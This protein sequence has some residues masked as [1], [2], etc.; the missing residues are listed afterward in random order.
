M[1]RGEHPKPRVECEGASEDTGGERAA[2]ESLRE[3]PFVRR[4]ASAAR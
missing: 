3:V 4:I 1:C 2:A